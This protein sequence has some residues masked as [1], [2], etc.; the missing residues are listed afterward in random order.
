MQNIDTIKLVLVGNSSG[1]TSLVNRIIT[2]NFSNNYHPTIGIEV[3]PITFATNTQKSITFNVWDIAGQER[4]AGL[5]ES[6]IQNADCAIVMSDVITEKHSNELQKYYDYV[7]QIIPGSPIIPCVNKVDIE[8]IG[9]PG[10][11]IQMSVKNNFNIESPFL[12]LAKL[13][14]NDPNIQ[15]VSNPALPSPEE[16][17]EDE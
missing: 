12:E 11:F 13:F 15:F 1:K 4:Y 6:C 2:G 8:Q 9:N 16:N 10:N 3:H 17:M 14:L 7:Q 5:R